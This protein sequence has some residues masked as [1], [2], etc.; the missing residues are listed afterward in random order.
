M[1]TCTKC[2]ENLPF[3]EFY[4]KKSGLSPLCKTCT[5]EQRRTQT[6]TCQGCLQ[7]LPLMDFPLKRRRYQAVCRICA[8]RTE[9]TLQTCE[10]CVQALPLSAFDRAGAGYFPRC[11]ACRLQDVQGPRKKRYDAPPTERRCNR[12]ATVKAITEFHASAQ[13]HAQG[14]RYFCK[15][16]FNA[17]RRDITA[18]N[19]AERLAKRLLTPPRTTKRCSKCLQE[20]PLISFQRHHGTHQ[21]QCRDC[22]RRPDQTRRAQSVEEKFWQYVIP[23][24]PD[25]CWE[26]RHTRFGNGYGRLHVQNTYY[27]AHRVS[28]QLHKG[29]I[30][31]GMQVCH[32]CDNPPCCNPSH[33][34]LGTAEDNA[35]DSMLKG[36]KSQLGKDRRG[37]KLIIP[38]VRIIKGLAYKE[39][40]KDLA[41]FFEVKLQTIYD[42]WQGR[43]WGD[44]VGIP[45]GFDLDT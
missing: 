36:R 15:D 19:R 39:K 42:I 18:K 7:R 33:L 41:A 35:N 24:D 40:A 45:P 17:L 30:P 44:I 14:Y 11:T 5:K 21:P 27:R 31:E 4:R 38:D 3:S 43:S 20:L 32:T 29:S 16:C 22:R 12:C 26:W 13:P 8:P 6:K 37:K 23:G 10:R 9:A 34:F 28:Y 25:A 1:K 2:L